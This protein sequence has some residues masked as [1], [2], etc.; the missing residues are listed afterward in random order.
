MNTESW[1]VVRAPG[2]PADL[3]SPDAWALHAFSDVEREREAAVWGWTDQW[4][5]PWVWHGV[6][7]HQE[8]DRKQMLL[9][10]PASHPEDVAPE[11]AD[12][13]GVAL[14]VVGREANTHLLWAGPLAVRPAHAH[15][16]V[17]DVLL[18][19][20]EEEAA[21]L[22]C[23][24][25]VYTAPHAPE[26][27]AGPAALEPRTGEGRVPV[28]SPEAVVSRER[29]YALEQVSRHSTLH[30]PVPS[31]VLDRLGD[32]ATAVA[33]DAYRTLTWRDEIPEDRLDD[34][35]RLWTRMSTD[36]PLGE[37]DYD[38]E[39]WDADRVRS[40]LADLA[41]RQQHVLLTVAEHVASGELVAFTVLQV[42]FP[43]VPFGFQ[44]DTLVL[45]EHRGH[46]LGTLVKVANL[47]ALAAW[48]PGVERIHTWNAQENAHMLAINVAL[49]F[50][51][52]GV[53]AVWQKRLA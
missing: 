2:P 15:D 48:R 53:A 25:V 41:G 23:T 9:V 28:D 20:V 11:P 16:G 26:P 38:E 12:V 21:A 7:R 27:P 19:A 22:G 40:H 36:T 1:R 37:L 49:G 44:E 14:V 13:V 30:L 29:G 32:D 8:Y 46:R 33:G 3:D 5:P 42:P 24:T 31:A 18:T 4:A 35:A 10:V 51:A 47:H 6:V 17:H 39:T 45:R 52:D 43:E 34:L 50:V